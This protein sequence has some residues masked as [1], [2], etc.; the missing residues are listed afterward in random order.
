MRTAVPSAAS[1]MRTSDARE[2]L[3][4]VMLSALTVPETRFLE[5]R[6]TADAS[7]DAPTVTR[8]PTARS[9][10]PD[11]YVYDAPSVAVR[12][13]VSAVETPPETEV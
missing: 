12:V 1:R 10:R 6:A 4:N 5:S 13:T 8:S 11:L 2:Y 7:A 3:P 9:V